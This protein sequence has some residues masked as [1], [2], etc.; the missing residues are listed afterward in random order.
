MVIKARCACAK[1]WGTQSV[2][3]GVGTQPV[4]I[5]YPLKH[6]QYD[7]PYLHDACGLILSLVVI[8]WPSLWSARV[9]NERQVLLK[10]GCLFLLSSSAL[11]PTMAVVLMDLRI[12]LVSVS[13]TVSCGICSVMAI[14]LELSRCPKHLKRGDRS[15][16]LRKTCHPV[17]D[18][19][20]ENPLGTYQ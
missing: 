18:L 10:K 15:W 14:F 5:Y 6:D 20:V 7:L 11:V 1:R 4:L 16:I 19:M 12:Y 17:S 9:Q 3:S 2:K 13:D 8:G